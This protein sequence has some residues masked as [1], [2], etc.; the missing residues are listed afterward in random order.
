MAALRK[1]KVV[2]RALADLTE[3][4]LQVLAIALRNMAAQAELHRTQLESPTPVPAA[5]V[6]ADPL[7]GFAGGAGT[8]ELARLQRLVDRLRKL[9]RTR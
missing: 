6:V 2:D 1:I 3:V 5:H 8:Y 4:D 7:S 9:P